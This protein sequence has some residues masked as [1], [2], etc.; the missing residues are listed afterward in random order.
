MPNQL[1]GIVFD[2]DGTLTRPNL[3]FKAMYQRCGVCTS[4]DLILEI[5][6]MPAEERRRA[7]EIVD[8]MEEHAAQ[9]AELMDGVVPLAQFLSSKSIPMAL[10]TRNSKASIAT[11]HERL[12]RPNNLPELKP[13][14]CRAFKPTKPAPDALL[15]IAEQWGAP[16]HHLLMVGDSPS[17]DVVSGRRAGAMTALVDTGRRHF[18]SVGGK[19][20]LV[21]ESQPD[22][23][24]CQPDELISLLQTHFHI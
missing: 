20:N 21:G 22:F 6:A 11:F 15:H 10:I 3:D 13:A 19:T 8:E 12:W 14:L 9:T 5:E 2:M 16:P 4:K 17:N 18:E 24:V 23:H 1:V 7:W